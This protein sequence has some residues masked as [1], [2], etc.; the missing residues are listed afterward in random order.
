MS[1]AIAQKTQPTITIHD[2]LE[3]GKLSIDEVCTLAIRS[4][5]GFYQD[6][7]AGLVKI[8]KNGRKSSV[9]GPIAKRYIAGEPI[10]SAS[11]AE[12]RCPMGLQNENPALGSPPVR[13]TSE[14]LPRGTAPGKRGRPAGAKPIS[15][16][17]D[18]V[19]AAEVK[20]EAV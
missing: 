7:K 15:A 5:T 4:K 3:H 12:A 19:K 6:V 20:R 13:S 11:S 9:L 18:R 1:N 17:L 16:T 2:R 10:D 8:E 14:R